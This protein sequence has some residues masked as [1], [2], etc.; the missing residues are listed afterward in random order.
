[1]DLRSRLEELNQVP[2]LAAAEIEA[3]EIVFERLVTAKAICHSVFGS[4]PRS[5]SVLLGAVLAELGASAR[6]I[7][8][9]D[10]S[11]FS[12]G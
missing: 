11:K 3:A 8:A 7:I 5:D 9:D 2:G 10:R 12:E 6:W 4:T 1:M